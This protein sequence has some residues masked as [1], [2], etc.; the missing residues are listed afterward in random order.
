MIDVESLT[1]KYG[2]QTALDKVTLKV[3]TGTVYGLVGP[4]GSGKTTL[5]RALCGLLKPDSGSAQVLG[6]DVIAK[7]EVV[8]QTVGY[9]SQ[10]F[11]LYMDL[12]ARENI[13]FFARMHALTDRTR[14]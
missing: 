4:N 3:R 7:P 9:M 8:R 5:V 10:R 11:S 12:T 2:R 6:I 14:R 1:R 13:D